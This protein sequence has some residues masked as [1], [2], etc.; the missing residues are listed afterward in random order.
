MRT[1]KIGITGDTHGEL[2][3]SRVYQAKRENITHLIVCGDFGYIWNGNYKEQKQLD[4]LNKIGVQILF[5]DGNH[6]N[7]ELLNNHPISTMYGGKVHR[8]RDNIIHLM[9]GEIYTINHKKYLAFGGANSVDIEY[10]DIYGNKKRRIQGK[11]WWKEE[12]PNNS[13]KQ[14]AFDNLEKHNFTVDY[15][16]THTCHSPGA[17]YLLNKPDPDDV[18][19]FLNFLRNK[20]NYKYWFFGHFH[21][22]YDIKELKS[23]CLYDKIITID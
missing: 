4:Y 13:D 16:L 8:I 17:Y 21:R 23:C 20:I 11:D 9:R 5:V 1:I 2:N 19:D 15:V 7:H 12:K 22:N 3:F 14:N 6:E 10:Y 18:S